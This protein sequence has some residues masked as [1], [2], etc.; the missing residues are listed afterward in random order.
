MYQ[1]RQWARSAPIA[2]RIKQLEAELAML[3]GRQRDE[4]VVAIVTVVGPGVV[5]SARELWDHRRASPALAAAFA[6][7]GIR[8]VKQL[9]KRLRALGLT[10]VG[11]DNTGALWTIE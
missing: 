8:S 2:R 9:G 7:A 3:R 10:R 5:F 1:R 11:A 4:L 6:D